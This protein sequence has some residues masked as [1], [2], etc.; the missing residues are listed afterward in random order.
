MAKCR[1]CNKTASYNYSYAK[2][3]EYCQTHKLEKMINITI[4][5]CDHENCKRKR[6]YNYK[7]HKAKYC[8]EH[9]LEEMVNVENKMCESEGCMRI[10]HYN[11]KGERPKY[12]S[13]HTLENMINLCT[14]KCKS[15]DCNKTAI[16]N[17]IGESPLKCKIHK[18]ENMENVVNKCKTQECNKK[19]AKKYE[20]Y[21]PSCYIKLY[22]N[23]RIK[24]RTK[25]YNVINYIHTIFN[26][27]DWKINKQI[28]IGTCKQ[29]PDLLLEVDK[30]IIIVEI[31]E[32]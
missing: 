11:M 15:K 2:K 1:K 16:Y 14:K 28:N 13:N 24:T 3:G 29:T 27:Y 32:Y 26:K 12:C 21:C 8:K 9:K 23:K 31:N 7:G 4:K 20:R 25:E 10:A 22:P 5:Y 30:Y 18:L 19:G 17:N 6:L